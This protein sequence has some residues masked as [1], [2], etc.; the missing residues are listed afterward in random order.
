MRTYTFKVVVEPDGERWHAYC[1]ALV[2]R[3]AA[4]W[5]YT[6]E[7]ALKNIDEVVKMVVESLVEHG[8][9]LPTE[10]SDEVR[11]S[12]QPEVAVIV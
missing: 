2:R 12:L 5:G 6:K 4:T 3:G 9:P 7:E 8:E 11:L 1:P 10:P